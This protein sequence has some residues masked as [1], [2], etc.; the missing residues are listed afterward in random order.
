MSQPYPITS[1][2]FTVH[3][4]RSKNKNELSA[5]SY[6]KLNKQQNS[7][8]YQL[9]TIGFFGEYIGDISSQSKPN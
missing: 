4:Y 7:K 6:P 2:S 9:K 1:S 5:F 3:P 8:D